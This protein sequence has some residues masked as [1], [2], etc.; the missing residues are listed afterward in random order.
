MQN[1]KFKKLYEYCQTLS[2]K[3]KRN[4]VIKKVVELTNSQ[5]LRAAI[6]PLDTSVTRGFFISASNTEHPFYMKVGG[7]VVVLAKELNDCWERF[8]NVKEAMHLLDDSDEMTDS[9]DKFETLLDDW[10]G[11][12]DLSNP[13]QRADIRAMWMALACLCPETNRLEFATLRGKEQIDYFG[14][15]TKLKIPEYYVP[16]LFTHHYENFLEVLQ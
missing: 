15:A 1:A 13:G 10:C 11:P 12:P 6:V 4:D 14:I 8:I 7:H 2:P 16:F 9:K 5:P 3:V